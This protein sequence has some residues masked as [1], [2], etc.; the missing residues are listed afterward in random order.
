MIDATFESIV[1]PN[2]NAVETEQV[3]LSMSVAHN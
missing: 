1:D 2:P 3:E